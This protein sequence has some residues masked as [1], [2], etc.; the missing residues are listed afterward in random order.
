MSTFRPDKIETLGADIMKRGVS[1]SGGA[2]LAETPQPS[3]RERR[4]GSQEVIK[5]RRTSGKREARTKTFEK[6]WTV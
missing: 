2:N 1:L 4:A 3:R 6:M 5:D